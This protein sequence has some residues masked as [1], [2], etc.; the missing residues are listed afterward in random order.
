M[1]RATVDGDS[2]VLETE[3]TGPVLAAVDALAGLRGVQTRTASLEDVYLELT[4]GAQLSEQ[5]QQEQQEQQE[6]ESRPEPEP[7][8]QAQP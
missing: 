8:P 2:V 3:D 5:E 4:G 6:S 7:Q 1:L